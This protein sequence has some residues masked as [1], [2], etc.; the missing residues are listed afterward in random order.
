MITLQ[1][2]LLE[3]KKPS[4]YFEDLR[5]SEKLLLPLANLINVPQNK[6]HHCEGD[7]WTHTMMVIDEAAKRRH[8]VKNP[9]G[10]MLSAVCHD[11]GKAVCTSEINGII[12][13]YQH[14]LEGI[15]IVKEFLNSINTDEILTEY[16][17]NMV[18][19]HMQPN[20]MA[21][22]N[23]AIKKTNKMFDK[24]IEPLALIQLAICDGL[25]KIPSINTTEDFLLKRLEIFNDIMKKPY[26]TEYDLLQNGIN[27]DE[28]FSEILNF[29][30]KLRLA[31]IE[32][33]SSL[34][35]TLSYA[36]KL[37]KENKH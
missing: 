27:K 1:K 11:F 16:V 3:N 25:G 22:M 30:H 6:T 19:L 5:K 13:S 26:V 8:I 35:Q 34:R 4:E 23:S 18:K 15:P 29:A 28:Y 2:I 21:E 14:E 32:K 12:H 24:S 36:Y 10:F 7:V 9:L 31:G 37:K 17:L 20:M 33:H